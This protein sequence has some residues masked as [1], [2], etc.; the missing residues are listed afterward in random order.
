M[1]VIAEKLSCEQLWREGEKDG[2]PEG[3]PCSGSSSSAHWRGLRGYVLLYKGF[4]KTD[5]G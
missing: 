4:E 1:G 3:S 5:V 2:G